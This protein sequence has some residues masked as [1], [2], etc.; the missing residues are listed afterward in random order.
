MSAGLAEMAMPAAGG[1]LARGGPVPRP[2]EHRNLIESLRVMLAIIAALLLIDAHP[3]VR[4]PLMLAIAA[5]G[6]YA[7]TLLWSA[8]SGSGIGQRRFL[9]WLDAIW[10]LLLLSLEDAGR[11]Y[12]F[13]FL[14]FPVFFAAWRTGY[15][16]GI[17]IAAFSC[18]ASLL[19]LALR[20]PGISWVRLLAPHLSLFLIA[21]LLVTLARIE[22]QAR[23]SQVLAAQLIANLDPRRGFDCI[24]PGLMARIAGERGAAVAILAMRTFEGHNRVFCW[25]GSEEPAELS[26]SAAFP[27]AEQVLSLADQFSFAFAGARRWW[28]HDRQIC[29]DQAAAPVGLARADRDILLALADLLGQPRLLSVPLSRPGI[30]RVRLL[31]AGERLG[32]D[33][34]SLDTMLHVV[35]QIGPSL[36]NAYLRERLV[37]EAAETERARIGRDL[38]DSAIQ[39][40]IGL[41]FAL[42]AVH[43]R[44]GPNNPITPDLANL[45]QMVGEELAAA[46]E[47][48]SGLR[49]A[50]GKGGT[51]L[52]NAVQRQARR[53]GELFGIAVEVDVEGE[54]PVSRRMA[55]E[56]F[57]IVAE[58]LSNIRRHTQARRASI[59]LSAAG[60]Q[61][62]LA[63]RNANEAKRP[64]A[65]FTPLSLTERANALGGSVNIERDDTA[66]T[67]TVSVPLPAGKARSH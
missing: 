45:V 36:E 46:R 44:A 66:T 31:V 5:F 18:L 30:G 58:G 11:T 20:D 63:I 14:F 65:D 16:E 26:E 34:P 25:D 62:V 8:A 64:A 38:H 29:L 43:R 19:V 40:Y 41:K 35:E 9:Y 10:F 50:P 57:H 15:R 52:S 61:L 17:A 54:M 42:E 51:L 4:A 3:A 49:G 48:I 60:G 39:P 27:I 37:V 6:A 47:V 13:P 32:V 67:V 33:A 23:D 2:T 7:A 21:P 22:R 53:F 1:A 59:S 55:G 12:Y 28:Q 24:I 56:L